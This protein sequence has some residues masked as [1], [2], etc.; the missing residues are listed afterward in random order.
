MQ[1]F[2]TIK[3]TIKK[4]RKRKKNISPCWASAT[5]ISINNQDSIISGWT[6]L[7]ERTDCFLRAYVMLIESLDSIV[8]LMM[9]WWKAS[10]L[11]FGLHYQ[12]ISGL[13]CFRWFRLCCTWTVTFHI[14]KRNERWTEDK[15]EKKRELLFF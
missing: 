4:D 6:F 13:I 2:F 8:V 10:T 5:R 14:R 3:Q 1:K 11:F 15:K 9:L 12:P 7:R